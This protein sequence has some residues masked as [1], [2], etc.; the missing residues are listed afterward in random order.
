MNAAAHCYGCHSR[1]G[2]APAEFAV[3]IHDHLGRDYFEIAMR[4][5]TLVKWSKA[6]LQ[7]IRDQLREEWKRVSKLRGEGVTG[8][9]EFSIPF[10]EEGE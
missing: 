1:L 6:D 4:S 5:V 9:I 8:R 2:E 10:V 7:T 3:W